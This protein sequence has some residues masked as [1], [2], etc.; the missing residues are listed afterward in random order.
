MPKSR[1]RT[2]KVYTPP[3]DLRPQERTA[4]AKK[5]PSPTWVPITALVL[6]VVGIGWLVTY[7]LSGGL[8]PVGTWGYWN[9]AIGFAALVASLVVLSRWR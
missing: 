8:F 7:Y 1:V 9:L 5:K 4:A 3:A 2:K 6:I